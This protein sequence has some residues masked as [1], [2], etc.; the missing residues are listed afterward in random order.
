MNS[1]GFRD[2]A[3]CMGMGSTGFAQFIIFNKI[4]YMYGIIKIYRIECIPESIKIHQKQ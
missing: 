2:M 4:L 3:K 1:V